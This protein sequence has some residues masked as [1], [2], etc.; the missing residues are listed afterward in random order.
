MGFTGEHARTSVHQKLLFVTALG[1]QRPR[2]IFSSGP[3]T[4]VKDH[5]YSAQIFGGVYTTTL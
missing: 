5:I 3:P 2:L 1:S 4:D